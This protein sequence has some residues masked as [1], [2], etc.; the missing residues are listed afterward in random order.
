M[1]RRL[2]RRRA[3]ATLAALW[4][5]VVAAPAQA[6]APACRGTLYLTIDTGW[7]D[8]A[9]LVAE[10]LRKH[11]VRATLFLANELTWRGDHSMDPSWADFWR[12]M[13]ADGHAFGTH[14]WRHWY[15]RADKG[16]RIRYASYAGDQSEMLDHEAMCA[17]LAAPDRALQ[18]MTGVRMSPIWRAPGGRT[19]PQT[20]RWAAECGYPQHVHWAP[21][22]VLGD[23]LP[24]DKHP[25]KA[26][27]DRALKNLKDGDVMLM[28][29]GIRSRREPFQPMLDA[30]LTGLKARGFCFATIPERQR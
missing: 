15:F 17:E 18:Q 25:N 30:L 21:A 3:A 16:D 1:I 24:S 7:M 13:A 23:A 29:F 19:T 14:T 11:Q 2:L 28:H 5:A 27:L 4:L 20:L 8:Q 22:G 26:L 9:E 12:R 10:I 6:A